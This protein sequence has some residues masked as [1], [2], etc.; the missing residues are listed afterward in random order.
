MLLEGK[1]LDSTNK[2]ER[3]HEMSWSLLQLQTNT[4]FR[5]LNIYLYINLNISMLLHSRRRKKVAMEIL[6]GNQ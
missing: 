5:I 4:H 1:K 3:V 6:I 2:T